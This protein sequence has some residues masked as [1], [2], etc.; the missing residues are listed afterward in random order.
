[1]RACRPHLL[2]VDQPAIAWPTR[3]GAQ[4]G[5]IGSGA[6]LGKQL[7]PDL[8]TAQR[9]PCEALLDRHYG[10]S[11]QRRRESEYSPWRRIYLGGRPP[12]VFPACPAT[13][14]GCRRAARPAWPFRGGETPDQLAAG[15]FWQPPCP[16]RRRTVQ[17]QGLGEKIQ[18]GGEGHGRDGAPQFLGDHAKFHVS[19]PQAAVV[20]G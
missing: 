9:R 3:A 16:L 18:R 13:E 7:T 8:L 1:M 20:L 2:A 19:Q 17:Q 15:D 6:G 4:G 5:E 10:E 12:S 11:H 14:P